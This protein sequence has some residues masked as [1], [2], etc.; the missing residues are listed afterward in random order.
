MI[1][2]ANMKPIYWL[3]GAIIVVILVWA[4]MSAGRD[5]AQTRN[6]EVESW[7]T[8]SHNAV[9]SVGSTFH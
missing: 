2:M 4:L 7:F 9:R 1:G 8:K 3:V 6:D 5:N